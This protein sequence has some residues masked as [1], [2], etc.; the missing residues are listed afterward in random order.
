MMELGLLLALARLS[1]RLPVRLSAL[2]PEHPP[3][4][5]LQALGWLF[6]ADSWLSRRTARMRRSNVPP[7][8]VGVAALAWAAARK[9][10]S[11]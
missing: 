9:R 11:A 8:L 5:E 6:A 3:H 2:L 1:E 4:I 7:M 10:D